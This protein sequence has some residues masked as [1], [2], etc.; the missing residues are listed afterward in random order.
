MKEVFFVALGIFMGVSMV[1]AQNIVDFEEL[2]L[3]PESNWN[4]NDLSGSFTSKYLTFYNAFDPEYSYWEG[5]S[6]TNETDNSTYNWTNM[7]SSSAGGGALGSENYVTAYDGGFYSSTGIL[8]NKDIAP[9]TIHGM[10]VCL[11]TYASLY[12]DDSDF[13]QEGQHW[14]KLMIR[15]YNSMLDYQIEKEVIL[16]DYRFNT[17]PGYKFD[18]WTYISLDWIEDADSLSFWFESSDVGEWGI[19]TPT[20]F[21]MDEFNAEMPLDIPDLEGE[22]SPNIEIAFGETADLFILAKGGVQPYSYLWDNNNS[23]DY[24]YIQNPIAS[25]DVTTN[26]TVTVTDAAGN[27]TIK[28]VTVQINPTNIAETKTVK[29]NI[30]QDEAEIINI[31]CPVLINK[32]SIYD[33]NGRILKTSYPNSDNYSIASSTFS[34]A[35]YIIN[36]QHEKGTDNQK[37]LIRNR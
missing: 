32:I 37:I 6:Y 25:P 26:Y 15:A 9:E 36:I 19:N 10:Y 29:S 22:I 23:L 11:N 35:L 2:D 8:I 30:F 24:D 12:M 4:G 7:F 31:S 33:I 28:T 13:Y 17:I 3:E 16:A 14:F 1:V 27:E 21:C 34:D 20:Y 5:F 18:D